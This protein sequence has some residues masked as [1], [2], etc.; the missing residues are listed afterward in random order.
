[1]IQLYRKGVWNDER[2]VNVIAT[3]CFLKSN[4]SKML[5]AALKFFLGG[6]DENEEEEKKQNIEKVCP[7]VD[8]KLTE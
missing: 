2:T 8:N 3:A 7:R 4:D 1:M 5:T 6:T